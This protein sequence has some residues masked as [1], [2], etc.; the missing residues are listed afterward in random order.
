MAS[1]SLGSMVV[2][3][4]S[5]AGRLL[6]IGIHAREAS[7]LRKGGTTAHMAARQ[8]CEPARRLGSG[9]GGVLREINERSVGG[10]NEHNLVWRPD[11]A[12]CTHRQVR[13]RASNRLRGNGGDL[14]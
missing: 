9:V 8:E 10:D 3:S 11:C 14:P 2:P 6:K 13:G 12:R 7:P 4:R 1:V 5:L